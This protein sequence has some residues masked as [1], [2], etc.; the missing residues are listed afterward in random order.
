MKL[1]ELINQDNAPQ[2]MT[3]LSAEQR[4][5]IMKRASEILGERLQA[6]SFAEGIAK[7][8][9]EEIEKMDF[10]EPELN[11]VANELLSYG[12]GLA[13]GEM[14]TKQAMAPQIYEEAYNTIITKIAE[15]MGEEAAEQVDGALREAGGEEQAAADEV[16]A[17]KEEITE[18]VAEGLVEEAGGLEQVTQDPELSA[19]ILNQASEVAEQIVEEELASQ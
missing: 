2:R 4:D 17:L 11:K 7:V 16:E 9:A 8:A 12:A 14:I 19:D 5:G 10:S 6:M 3:K 13:D 18:N 15:V 1:H